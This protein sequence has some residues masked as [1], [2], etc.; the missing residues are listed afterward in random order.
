MSLDPEAPASSTNSLFETWRSFPNLW[1]KQEQHQLW[2][3][4][5][6]SHAGAGLPLAP[7]ADRRE[8]RT[9]ETLKKLSVPAV[10]Q[11]LLVPL[12]AV[13]G[14]SVCSF[15]HISGSPGVSGQVEE[16]KA[17]RC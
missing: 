6:C 2:F 12:D 7:E 8:G 1:Q 3:S 13:C 5:R 11:T 16:E 9:L 17:E 10:G 14:K 15:N 4:L